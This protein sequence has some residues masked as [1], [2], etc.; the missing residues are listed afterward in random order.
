MTE[1]Q[2]VFEKLTAIYQDVDRQAEK[3]EAV[4]AERL[5]CGQGCT[6]CC[7]D[8]LTVFEVEAEYIRRFAPDI[9]ARD[10]HPKG[11]C[12]FLDAAGACRIY[13]FRPYVCRTQGLPLRWF[14]TNEDDDPVEY[15]DICPLNESGTPLEILPAD[16]CWEIGPFEGRLATLQAEIDGGQLKRVVLRDLFGC[17]EE[18]HD[19]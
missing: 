6:D 13:T 8:D 16:T 10:V 2:S 14:D 5:K 1:W 9:L 4:H 7:V 12:A 15:R 19:A 11:Q 3:L 17:D 18:Y